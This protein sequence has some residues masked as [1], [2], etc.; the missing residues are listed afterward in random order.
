MTANEL[1]K[2]IV[3]FLNFQGHYAWR[4]GNTPSRRVSNLVHKG[5]GDV[6]CVCKGGRHL[7]VE[8]KVG[9]DKQSK[10]QMDHEEGI[11]KRKGAYVVARDFNGFIQWYG[12][13]ENEL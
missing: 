10:E 9:E 12:K 4:Q 2:L 6:M 8:V 11:T 5:V 3:N 13:N 1:T 7:E